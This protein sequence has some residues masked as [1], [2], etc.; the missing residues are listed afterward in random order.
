MNREIKRPG[1]FLIKMLV[2]LTHIVFL[3]TV[4]L[5][6]KD[7]KPLELLKL[8]VTVIASDLI[9]FVIFDAIDESA[10]A[11]DILMV[12][13]INISLIFQSCFCSISLDTKH[14]ITITAGMICYIIGYYAVRNS[15]M[16]EKY[17]LF[18][19]FAVF[20]I[21]V[22]IVAFAGSRSMWI[23]IGGFSLQPSEL[24]KPLLVLICATSLKTQQDKKQIGMFRIAPNNIGMVA[25]GVIIILFQWWCRDLGSIPIFAG[26][27]GC[28]VINRMCYPKAKF[29]K[30]KFAALGVLVVFAGLIAIKFAPGYVKDRLYVDIWADRYGDGYQQCEALI[31]IAEGGW[32]GKGPGHGT[33]YT[34][35][36]QAFNTDTVFSTVSEEW[37]LLASLLF[38]A[39]LVVLLS[40]TIINVPRCYY[41]G[42][43]A[44]GVT[45]AFIIQMSLNVF[46]SC[47]LIPFTGVT[48]PFLSNG[49]TSM[50]TSGFMIGMLRA[51]QSPDFVRHIVEKTPSKTRRKKGDR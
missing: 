38:V 51:S 11:I 9:Y 48:L 8:S 1:Y 25:V 34:V 40:T 37:G 33:L 41:H 20:A 4:L 12:L 27:L 23:T 43:V 31:A 21:M 49:G 26:I 35:D 6:G 18:Y 28:A 16:S 3:G 39:L 14:L 29:S 50:V 36:K 13:I 30:K 15:F 19:Y 42:T 2:L 45:A 24:L 44:V 46:G 47:N 17:K 32:F 7:V 22:I 5:N 10:H